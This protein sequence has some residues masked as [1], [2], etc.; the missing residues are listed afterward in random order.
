MKT[1]T[2]EKYFLPWQVQNWLECIMFPIS[3]YYS[4]RKILEPDNRFFANHSEVFKQED[5][6]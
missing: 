2:V 4:A 5:G 1:L 6:I 3:A